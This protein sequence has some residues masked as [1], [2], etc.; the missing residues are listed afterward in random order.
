[1][2]LDWVLASGPALRLVDRDAYTRR[3]PRCKVARGEPCVY[4]RRGQVHRDRRTG[5]Y[6]PN[7]PGT[8]TLRP[9]HERRRAG[10]TDPS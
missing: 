8:P 6:V 2:S 4:T 9:H 10:V 1:M 3:C 7:V 5:E